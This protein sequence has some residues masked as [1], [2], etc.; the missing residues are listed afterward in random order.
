MSKI[1][2]WTKLPESQWLVRGDPTWRNNRTGQLL[3]VGH[4]EGGGGVV[5]V[6]DNNNELHNA[7]GRG[8]GFRT[9]DLAL[10]WAANYRKVQK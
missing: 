7:L 8:Y 4:V 1:S 2:G 5:Y 10:R 3:V 6:Q 9:F